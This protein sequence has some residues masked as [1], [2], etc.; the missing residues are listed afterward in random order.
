MELRLRSC[1]LRWLVLIIG[2]HFPYEISIN[3]WVFDM[4]SSVRLLF[5]A[6]PLA[7]PFV[8]LNY[9][10]FRSVV[11]VLWLLFAIVRFVKCF[12]FAFYHIFL[13]FCVVVLLLIFFFF[14]YDKTYCFICMLRPPSTKACSPSLCSGDC[15]WLF[16]KCLLCICK[17]FSIVAFYL[18]ICICCPRNPRNPRRPRNPRKPTFTPRALRIDLCGCFYALSAFICNWVATTLSARWS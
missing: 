3:P 13:L 9:S 2:D 15:F 12:S 18:I 17:L 10:K 7:P 1:Q 4:Q 16:V 6:K 5:S 8:T 11:F 14:F